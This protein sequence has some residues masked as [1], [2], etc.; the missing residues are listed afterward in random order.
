MCF[1]S[2]CPDLVSIYISTPF[3]N[4]KKSTLEYAH[5]DKTHIYRYQKSTLEWSAC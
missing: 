3:V 4:K 2:G 1:L 5:L